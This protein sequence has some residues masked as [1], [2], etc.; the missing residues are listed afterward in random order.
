M[1]RGGEKHRRGKGWVA[2][3]RLVRERDG[4][5]RICSKTPEENGQQLSVDHVK[6]Y[7]L[8]VDDDASANDPAN[9]VALCRSCHNRKTARA[10]RAY[11]KGDVLEYLRYLENVGLRRR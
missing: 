1:Y 11:I 7:R 2:A 4:V 8:F 5:C 6:P 10:E 9:L 3:R